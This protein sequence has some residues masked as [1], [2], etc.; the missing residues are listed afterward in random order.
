MRENPAELV[1][2]ICLDCD[3]VLTDGSIYVDDLGH[4]TKRFHVRDGLGLRIWTK[5]GGEVAIITGRS[6]AALRHRADELGILHLYQG[7]HDK[8]ADFGDLL[9]GLGLTASQAAF[10]GDDLPDLPVMK[11][12]GYPIAV[13]DAAKEVRDVAEF[14]TTRPGGLGAVREAVE[15]LLKTQDRWNEAMEFFG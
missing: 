9:N 10:I 7:S 3:G 5:L 6:S 2:L 12:A 1:E 14:V 15:H 8:V 11:L 4:E 13:A